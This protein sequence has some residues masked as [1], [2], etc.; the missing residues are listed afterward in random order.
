MKTSKAASET[1][2]REKRDRFN[3]KLQN[4]ILYRYVKHKTIY[5][6]WF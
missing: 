6:E 2:E 5:S 4:N 3:I 1:D